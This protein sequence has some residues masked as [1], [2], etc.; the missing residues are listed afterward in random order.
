[1]FITFLTTGFAVNE[2]TISYHDRM[3]EQIKKQR[4]LENKIKLKDS[5]YFSMASYSPLREGSG[6]R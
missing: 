6:C 1:M 2:R 3:N 4:P 5:E